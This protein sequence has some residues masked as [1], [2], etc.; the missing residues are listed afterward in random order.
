[1]KNRVQWFTGLLFMFLA[2]AVFGLQLQAQAAGSPMN[3]AAGVQ[4][5]TQSQPRAQ[6]PQQ[7][8]PGQATQPSGRQAPDPTDDQAQ[9]VQVFTGQIVKAGDRYVLQDAASSK[10][11]DIDHQEVVSQYEG[12]R[13]RVKGVLDPTG[14]MIHIQGGQH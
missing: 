8:Y 2:A 11:Y 7:Q 3:N 1:M 9:G 12:K 14:K 6:T 4:S 5:P 10:T 13:V